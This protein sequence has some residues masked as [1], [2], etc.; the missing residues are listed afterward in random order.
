MNTETEQ[1]SIDKIPDKK[2]MPKKCPILYI[3]PLVPGKE[4]H[5]IA[6]MYIFDLCRQNMPRVNIA[7][8]QMVASRFIFPPK[9]NINKFA[10][11]G[12]VEECMAQLFCD[13]GVTCL[14]NSDELKVVDLEMQVNLNGEIIPFSVSIK[15]SGNLTSQPILENYRGQKRKEIRP[16][17]PTFI[18]YT[19]TEIKRVRVIYIDEE[20]LRQGYQGT[21]EDEF[22]NEVYK[23]NDSNLTFKSGFLRRFIPRLPPNYILDAEYPDKLP[24]LKE[25]SFCKLATK[26]VNRQLYQGN[27][28]P[29]HPPL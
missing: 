8:Q 3:Y 4:P 7:F 28:E 14:N 29:N 12:I 17:P 27:L 21:T 11:G 2:T 22:H 1:E 10:T 24:Q 25:Q 23:N 6:A 20:I 15:N 16:L 13:I 5:A 9:I 19:E 26:E 18:V